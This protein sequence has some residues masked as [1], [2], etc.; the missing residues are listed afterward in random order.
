MSV[1]FFLETHQSGCEELCRRRILKLSKQKL[2][3][4]APRNET[5]ILMCCDP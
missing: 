2:D 4:M 3:S 5:T 1:P